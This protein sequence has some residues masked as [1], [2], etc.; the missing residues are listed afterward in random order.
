[1]EWDYGAVPESSAVAQVKPSYGPFVD[2]RAVDG[3]DVRVT[4]NPATD[5]P[6]AEVGT[7]GPADVD[8]AVTA[9][10]R[11]HDGAWGVL[12]GP[13]RARLL[14]RIAGAVAGRARELAV[15]ETLDT[16]RPVR[17][18]RDVDLPLAAAYLQSCAGWADKLPYAGHGPDPRPVGVV[19][20]LVESRSPLL[21]AVRRIAPALACGNAVVLVPDADAPLSALVLAQVVAEAG[22]PAGVLNVLP[23]VDRHSVAALAQADVD[24]VVVTASQ[25]TCREVAGDVAGTGRRLALEPDGRTVHV[26]HDDAPL[27]QA[28]DGVA[29]G[30]GTD[31]QVL[32]AEAVAEEFGELLRERLAGLRVGDPLDRNTDV[33]PVGTAERRE[34]AEALAA[35][36]DEEGAHRT[37][38]PAALPGRGLF[39]APTLFTDVAPT[40]RLA[41]E[42]V[43]GPLLPVLT[44]R[45][46]AEA[47][48]TASAGRRVRAAAVWTDKGS[49]A[50]WTARNLRAGVVWVNAVDRAD[51][52]AP[53]SGAVL[54][55]YLDITRR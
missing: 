53:S 28:V 25:R 16:G 52:A 29:D 42:E 43:T 36:A 45:T 17:A 15:L 38:S 40:M 22:L 46:P 27:D 11:A 19:G 48:A 7:A 47:V 35:A 26:V 49:R 13:E 39:V 24:A 32:V 31:Q 23:T 12:A 41:R 51:P 50:L 21:A 1:M 55:D 6:L 44:F 2:G 8:G 14:F 4:R 20:V 37:T 5:E 33:G 54:T 18:T 30:L 10:R 9:A 3:G 34:R